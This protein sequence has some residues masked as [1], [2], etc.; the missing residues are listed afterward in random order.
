V[1]QKAYVHWLI[2]HKMERSPGI[3]PMDHAGHAAISTAILA[4]DPDTAE[5]VMRRHP[6]VAWELVRSTLSR[7][8]QEAHGRQVA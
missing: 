8:P 4:R 1:V 6:R 7:S 2:S 5:V 3:D